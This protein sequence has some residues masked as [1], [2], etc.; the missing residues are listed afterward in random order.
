MAQKA[1]K[2]QQKELLKKDQKHFLHPTSNPKQQAKSGASIVLKRG[3][4][5][6]VEDIE[7][8]RYMDGL[9]SLWNVHIGH[10]NEE[11]ANV[12]Y[13]QMSTLA[14][15]SSFKGY[16]NPAAIELSEKLAEIAP[17]KLNSVF[18]TSGGSESNDT[19][20]KLSRFYWEQVGKPEKKK[21][22]SLERSYHGVTIGHSRQP[23]Y[24]HSIHFRDHT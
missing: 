22:I 9:S 1:A 23:I 21:I 19:A 15:A 5:I 18:Y 2:D 8:K 3:K 13:E 16:S 12:S 24:Q 10:G 14:Y 17:D 6:Y 4:G 20:F 7:G 11:L